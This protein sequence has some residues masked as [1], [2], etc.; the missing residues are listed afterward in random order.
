VSRKPSFLTIVGFVVVAFC[1]FS[2]AFAVQPMEELLPA[3]TTGFLS[4]PD[5]DDLQAKFEK[6]QIGQLA[7]DPVMK[8]FV[9]DLKRQIQ[10]KLS[11]TGGRLGISWEELS[12]VYGGEVAVGVIQPEY[13][14]SRFAIAFVVD[15]TGKK[16]QRDAVIRK[17]E[18]NLLKRGA[19]KLQPL[20]ASGVRIN[21]FELPKARGEREARQA[22]SFVKDDIL[23][24]S[25]QQD[26]AEGILGRIGNPSKDNLAS[27]A[28]YAHIHS[29]CAAEAGDLQPHIRWFVEPLRYAQTM[30]TAAGGKKKRGT[31]ILKVLDNQGFS[32]VKGAGGYVN[33]ATGEHE[34]LHRTLVYAPPVKRDAGDASKDKYDLAAR[35]LDFGSGEN[36]EPHSWVPR[37]VAAHATLTVD[38]QNAFKYVDT[39]VNELAGDK[40]GALFADVLDSILKDPN[41]PQLDIRGDIVA[42]MADRVTVISDY[43]LPI[44]P[45]SER[46]LIGIQ[47]V[48][49]KV[50]AA[51]V[52]RDFDALDRNKDGK[53][54]AAEQPKHRQEYYK[55]VLK[56]YNQPATGGLT[57]EQ[58]IDS[59]SV[60][61]ALNRSMENDPEAKKLRV[62]D[63][64]IW[65][66][67]NE[68]EVNEE[69]MGQ[70]FEMPVITFDGGDEF[71]DLAPLDSGTFTDEFDDDFEGD[72][73]AL[74]NSAITVAHGHILVSTRVEFLVKVLDAQKPLEKLA[75]SPDFKVVSKELT[76]LGSRK[77]T[78]RFFSRT[79]EE[80][81]ATYELIRQGKM[82]ESETILGQVLNRILSPDEEDGVREQ[83]ID[84]SKM[85]PYMVVRRY[86]GPAGGFAQAE[87][88]DDGWFITGVVLTKDP[89]MKIKPIAEEATI[90]VNDETDD[91]VV[92]HAMAPGVTVPR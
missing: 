2:C 55:R 91:S 22:F 89:A 31:D 17:I 29:R 58:Y 82:P 56:E 70:E 9:D 36:L 14:P 86:L 85:P 47:L 92:P 12:G 26:V 80:F 19:K 73:P 25:D 60:A 77:D 90:L 27:L 45:D 7:A 57:K 43:T 18:N 63:H 83:Q 78:V 8:P 68:P 81:R 76:K 71:G 48:D 42:N 13:N 65:E 1:M 41:G 30:R 28:A 87:P 64:L 54:T 23:V 50:R 62:G 37:A 49:E 33:L 3:T 74:P 66:I 72:Q 44:E 5:V 67:I 52:G 59:R 75:D 34:V 46:L 69:V 39:L 15:T 84:G 11:E 10:E 38:I 21:V 53:V 20:M 32:A 61:K 88:T 6:T 40:E 24:I 51:R 16:P 4:I 79:D 35:M